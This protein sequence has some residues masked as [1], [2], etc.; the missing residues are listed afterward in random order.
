MIQDPTRRILMGRIHGAF[1]VRGEVK[2]ESFADPPLAVFRYLPWTLRDASGQERQLAG[3]RGRVNAKGVVAVLPDVTDRDAA[4]ALRG[5]EIWVARDALPPPGPGE[6][7]WVDLQ[8]LR[9]IN[10]EGVDFGTVSH[11]FSTGAND[12][13]VV[14]GERERMLP[15]LEPEVIRQVDFEAGRISVDW[16]ADF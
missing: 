8:G 6:Y 4:E 13:L 14:Q 10:A 2:L 16:D 1:G 3:A 7:Y 15:F 12:V 5:A 9:V 11:L